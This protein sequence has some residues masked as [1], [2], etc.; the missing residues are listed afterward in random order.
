[1]THATLRV[2]Q[3]QANV[4]TVRLHPETVVGRS[5]DCTLKIASTQVSRRHCRI[6]DRDDGVFVEDL[7]S[8]NGTFLNGSRLTPNV[9]TLARPGSQLAIGPAT[10]VVE[11]QGTPLELGAV[12]LIAAPVTAAPAAIIPAL[13]DDSEPV[14]ATE[15]DP[16][17]TG[18]FSLQAVE[19]ALP[20]FDFAVA[21]ASPL[22]AP[23]EEPPPK[24]MRSLF[25]LFSRSK[26]NEEPPAAVPFLPASEPLPVNRPPAD[27]QDSGP[28][29]ESVDLAAEQTVMHE[30]PMGA[31]AE[32][33]A[34]ELDEPAFEAPAF[35]FAEAEIAEEPAG[36]DDDL[37]NF[38][39]QL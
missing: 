11:Y 13:P 18:A 10:F 15:D 20:E 35:G 22:P 25:G 28:G 6:V 8:A 34:P 7:G 12:P 16:E 32:A 24:R 38:L 3:K 1:M 19:E 5:L 27:A 14:E 39:Q 29:E 37:Q 33:I 23:V 30:H 2:L 36:G 17:A 4:R 21:E 9:L 31:E 26:K